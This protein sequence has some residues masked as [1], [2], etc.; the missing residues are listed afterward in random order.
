MGK[1]QEIKMGMTT[2]YWTIVHDSVF[3][4]SKHLTKSTC[5]FRVSA[6][7]VQWRWGRPVPPLRFKSFTQAM[8]ESVWFDPRQAR[9]T[10][11]KIKQNGERKAG[12][13]LN[14]NEIRFHELVV[15]D[16]F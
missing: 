12:E 5:A 7:S 13:W 1:G 4:E 9:R 2:R 15:W 14:G 16:I 11:T 10:D 8:L 3:G 6:F